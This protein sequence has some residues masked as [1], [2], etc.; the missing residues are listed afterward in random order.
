MSKGLINTDYRQA[1]DDADG[2]NIVGIR[3]GCGRCW[4]GWEKTK[5]KLYRVIL[6]TDNLHFAVLSY[7]GGAPVCSVKPAFSVL[8][9]LL[10]Y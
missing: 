7:L 3:W 10:T 6:F 1:G 8:A 9:H 4:F 5:I 2:N